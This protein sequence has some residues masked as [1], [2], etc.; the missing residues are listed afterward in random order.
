[1]E[2]LNIKK[3]AKEIIYDVNNWD[4][5]GYSL[6]RGYLEI[7][8][9]AIK[10]TINQQKMI[11]KDLIIG[12]LKGK[13]LLMKN[14]KISSFYTGYIEEYDIIKTIWEMCISNSRGKLSYLSKEDKHFE[15]AKKFKITVSIIKD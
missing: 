8:E 6:N 1:M 11:E 12:E 10:C 15:T 4:L 13:L 7:I 9:H 3:L 2:E 14:G 5:S